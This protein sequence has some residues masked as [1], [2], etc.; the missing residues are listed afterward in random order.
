MQR[1]SKHFEDVK[2]CGTDK[3]P[4][5]GEHR[6]SVYVLQLALMCIGLLTRNHDED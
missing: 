3:Y 4:R 6:Q 1:E 5:P 2:F